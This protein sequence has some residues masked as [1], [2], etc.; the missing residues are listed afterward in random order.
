MCPTE[1]GGRKGK[2]MREV[3]GGIEVKGE[4]ERVSEREKERV[5]VCVCV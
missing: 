5:R 4:K 1:M 3:A 2:E